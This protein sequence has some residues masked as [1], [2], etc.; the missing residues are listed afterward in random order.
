MA[1][2]VCI[3]CFGK[4]LAILAAVATIVNARLAV[5]LHVQVFKDFYSCH[6]AWTPISIKKHS[7]HSLYD[8]TSPRRFTCCI[9]VQL[10]N[11]FVNISAIIIRNSTKLFRCEGEDLKQDL[12][13]ATIRNMLHRPLCHKGQAR[14]ALQKT[15]SF[16]IDG[17]S[18]GYQTNNFQMHRQSPTHRP[19]SQHSLLS[20][21]QHIVPLGAFRDRLCDMLRWMP[22]LEEMPTSSP[23]VFEY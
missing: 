3:N 15:V 4:T 16:C 18:R 19:Q 17:A 9:Q 12:I 14:L 22:L 5:V 2:C 20:R 23:T 21:W 10:V 7:C 1:S 6:A 8:I 11:V 13:K